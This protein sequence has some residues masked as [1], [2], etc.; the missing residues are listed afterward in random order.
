MYSLYHVI[1]LFRH[2]VLCNVEIICVH[3]LGISLKIRIDINKRPFLLGGIF[4]F[5]LAEDT[6]ILS[7]HNLGCKQGYR[8]IFSVRQPPIAVRR[9][10]LSS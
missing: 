1:S 3:D 5:D 8:C 6:V 7:R 2:A 10:P 4:W 9:I